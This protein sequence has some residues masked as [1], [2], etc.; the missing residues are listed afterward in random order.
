MLIIDVIFL[1]DFILFWGNSFRY[2]DQV[3]YLALPAPFLILWQIWKARNCHRYDNRNVSIDKVIFSVTKRLFDINAMINP[4]RNLSRR[5]MNILAQL[6]F[7]QKPCKIYRPIIVKWLL[8]PR[9][10]Y[11]LNADGSSRLNSQSG[12]G[13]II[14]DAYGDSI[15]C[16]SCYLGTG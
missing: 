9:G 7:I 14:R 2:D 11:K 3:I 15:A 1:R 8:P 10:R 13:W 5:G 6:R 4:K 16:G 12:C